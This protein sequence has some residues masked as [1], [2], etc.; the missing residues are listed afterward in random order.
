[1]KVTHS[2]IFKAASVCLPT[3]FL[4]ACGGGGSSSNNSTT[5]APSANNAF[6]A[7][8]GIYTNVCSYSPN[9]RGSEA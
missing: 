1:M 5:P 3:L 2:T 4:E 6:A 9:V 8:Q 7:M